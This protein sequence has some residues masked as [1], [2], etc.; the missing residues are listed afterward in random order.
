MKRG[1]RKRRKKRG[2]LPSTTI[3]GAVCGYASQG[4]NCGVEV[5]LQLRTHSHLHQPPY[6]SEGFFPIFDFIK[7]HLRTWPAPS[8]EYL[9]STGNALRKSGGLCRICRMDRGRPGTQYRLE[10]AHERMFPRR[11]A[12]GRQDD[13]DLSSGRPRIWRRR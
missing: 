7:S 3:I 12:Q 9:Q 11:T 1:K 10:S 4:R 13:G 5:D 8:L 2:D 6:Y